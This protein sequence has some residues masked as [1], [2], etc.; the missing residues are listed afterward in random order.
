[1][2]RFCFILLEYPRDCFLALS[3]M[4]Y[5]SGTAVR[6]PSKAYYAFFPNL[7]VSHKAQTYIQWKSPKS[8]LPTCI[9]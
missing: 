4:D 2:H 9:K 3:Y 6:P 8:A 5:V 1:M 7:I